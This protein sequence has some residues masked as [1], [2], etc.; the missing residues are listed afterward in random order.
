MPGSEEPSIERPSST[1]KGRLSIVAAAVAAVV[2]FLLLIAG[3]A[4]GAP[5]ARQLLITSVL[6]V[7]LIAAGTRMHRR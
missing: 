5:G 6:L 4:I 1:P 2:L 3:T 7:G